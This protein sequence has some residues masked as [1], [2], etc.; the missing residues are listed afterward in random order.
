MSLYLYF[1][2][3]QGNLKCSSIQK[4]TNQFCYQCNVFLASGVF[5]LRE[6]IVNLQRLVGD[7][8]CH[9]QGWKLKSKPEPENPVL[10]E[11]L[12]TQTETDTYLAKIL[13]T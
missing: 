5:L 3:L 8:K 7:P 6:R 2:K 4:E 13:K 9:N 10:K 1:H 11:I 12:E